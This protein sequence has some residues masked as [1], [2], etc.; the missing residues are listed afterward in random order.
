M[1]WGE[2]LI[3]A[4]AFAAGCGGQVG[5]RARTRRALDARY[6]QA[7]RALAQG[8]L[9]EAA[10][11]FEALAR[12]D[13]HPE[14]RDL[15]RYRLARI[16]EAE[17]RPVEARQ[18]LEALVAE[19][20]PERAALARLQLAGQ[21]GE[22]ALRALAEAFPDTV[23]ADKAVK[24]VA[25][26]AE[27]DGAGDDSD[28]AAWLQTLADRHPDAAVADNALWWKAHL[29]IERL[30]DLPAARAT[31]RALIARWPESALVDDAL[32]LL[33]ALYRRVG[34]F[35]EAAR[36]Y[37][38]LLDYRNDTS[39]LVGSYRSA[40][41]DD[42]A[43]W[44]GRVRH[45]GLRDF[46]GAAAAYERLLADFDSSVLRDDALWGLAQAR[47]AGGDPAGARGAVARLLAHH[48][49]SRHAASAR[50]LAQDPR[51]EA[52]P[53]DPALLWVRLGETLE[54]R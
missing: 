19:G 3:L 39:F 49:G 34:A 28:R 52:A 22:P 48:P 45:H 44:A 26:G 9:D 11:A 16:A 29:E 17:G 23:A 51:P 18:R 10:R 8:R 50:A 36:T 20:T 25:L 6:A 41:L 46:A 13:Q 32:W 35:D 53:A 1:R 43:L 15:A 7:E 14:D 31:L 37:E 47:A 4:L 2:V 21:G 30:G 12:D 38:A 33:A 27:G 5:E 24:R 42:A 54:G 40:R